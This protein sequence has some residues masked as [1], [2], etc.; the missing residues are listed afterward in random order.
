MI[1]DL[2][3]AAALL[4]IWL[5]V[6]GHTASSMNYTSSR[7]WWTHL[8]LGPMVPM[9]GIAVRWYPMEFFL[10]QMMRKNIV[11]FVRKIFLRSTSEYDE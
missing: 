11:D 8:F 1:L 6:G 4:L 10:L 9:V 7:R 2:L 5:I 3:L